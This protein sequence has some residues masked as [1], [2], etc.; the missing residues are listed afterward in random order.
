VMWNGADHVVFQIVPWLI[1]VRIL[2]WLVA[3]FGSECLSKRAFLLLRRSRA[4]L[5]ALDP[6]PRT[7]AAVNYRRR[8]ELRPTCRR[9]YSSM[10]CKS[11]RS[12]PLDPPDQIIRSG[13]LA[14]RAPHPSCG[15]PSGR[16]R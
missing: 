11:Y 1:T 7:T 10:R 6:P 12:R 4:G 15:S 3:L 13:T 2:T 9:G 5:S 14:H 8:T 16:P